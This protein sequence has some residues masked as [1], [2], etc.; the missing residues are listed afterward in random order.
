[1]K[2]IL[3]QS[4]KAY[5]SVCFRAGKKVKTS[6]Y[7]YFREDLE[8]LGTAG[9]TQT[10]KELIEFLLTAYRSRPALVSQIRTLPSQ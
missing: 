3:E 9:Y 7:S 1:M 5:A 4:F 8:T 6:K 2:A 10:Q